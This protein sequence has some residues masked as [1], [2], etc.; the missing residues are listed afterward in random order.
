MVHSIQLTLLDNLCPVCVTFIFSKP[1]V[2]SIIYIV[3]F[4]TR[5]KVIMNRSLLLKFSFLVVVIIT[6]LISNGKCQDEDEDDEDIY[7]EELG[8]ESSTTS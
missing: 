8:E 4:V 1:S 3:F 7:D 5:E 2:V 6:F